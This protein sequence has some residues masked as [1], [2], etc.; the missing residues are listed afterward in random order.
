MI[1]FN[2]SAETVPE[3]EIYKIE[4]L[5]KYYFVVSVDG[6]EWCYMNSSAGSSFIRS[7]VLSYIQF[8]KVD[9][10]RETYQVTHILHTV[11]KRTLYIYTA[12]EHIKYS[13][14]FSEKAELLLNSGQERF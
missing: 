8:A 11:L 9:I 1:P 2:T 6:N 14:V 10:K 7:C 3:K 13:N 4:R 12:W 5:Q